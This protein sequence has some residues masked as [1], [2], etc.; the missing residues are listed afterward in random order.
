M[1]SDPFLEDGGERSRKSRRVGGGGGEEKR[2]EE[3]TLSAPFSS[4]AS[5]SRQ[6]KGEKGEG[7]RD[8]L[9]AGPSKEGRQRTVD[10]LRQHSGKIRPNFG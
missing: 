3:A 4:L 5:S 8:P 2:E 7:R 6:L 10:R 1:R 9:S